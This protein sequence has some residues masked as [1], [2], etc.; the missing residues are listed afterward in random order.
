MAKVVKKLPSRTFVRIEARQRST[1][2]KTSSI[3][4]FGQRFRK[5]SVFTQATSYS[6][7]YIAGY[8]SGKHPGPWLFGS[9]VCVGVGCVWGWGGGGG[10]GGR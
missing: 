6:H 1:Q 9:G 3:C 10:G 7:S 5:T 4:E 8:L 2:D